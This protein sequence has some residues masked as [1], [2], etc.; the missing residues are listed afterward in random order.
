MPTLG[1]PELI[2]ILVIIILIFGVGKLP[3]VGQALGK[4]MREFRGAAEGGDDTDTPSAPVKTAEVPRPA[5]A[6]EAPRT[7]PVAQVVEPPRPAPAVAATTAYTV[8]DGLGGRVSGQ[9]SAYTA[10]VFMLDA[11]FLNTYALATRGPGVYG[12]VLPWWR[13]GLA[14]AVLSAAAYWIAIWAMSHAHIAA[15]A[16]LRETSILFVILM[17]ARLLK[18]T[19]TRHRFAGATLIVAG[20]ILLRLA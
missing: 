8:V 6:V 12:Q 10:M 18:E 7:A 17:S 15:V 5:P 4:S 9:P 1:A 19:V 11:L 2:I 3:E 20:A 13:T 16:A 14:G